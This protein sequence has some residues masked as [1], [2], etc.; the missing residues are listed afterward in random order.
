[1]EIFTISH[2]W[3][4]VKGL[5]CDCLAPRRDVS[6]EDDPRLSPDSVEVVVGFLFP[7]PPWPA[8]GG[9]HCSSTR[10]IMK[11]QERILFAEIPEV[12]ELAVSSRRSSTRKN[13]PS[14]MHQI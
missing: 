9:N 6:E 7:S 13:H 8:R 5:V 12:R 1:M 3:S 11:Q 4:I 2:L 10:E 14:R